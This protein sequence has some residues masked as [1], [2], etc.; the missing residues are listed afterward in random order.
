M[1]I[2]STEGGKRKKRKR[3]KSKRNYRTNQYIRITNV[4]LESLLSASFPSPGA[5]VHLTFLGCPPTL[6]WPL[7]LLWGQL[8]LWSSS[9]V[10]LPPMSTA[11]RTSEF[12]F[13]RIRS[14]LLCISQTQILL[15][16]SC[17]FNL[18]LEGRFCVL[19]FSTLPL[20]SIVV[21]SPPL[22]VGRHRGLL[23]RLSWRTWVCSSEFQVWRWCSCL[24]CRGPGSTKYSGELV[25]KASGNMVL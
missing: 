4:F 1:L 10:F 9:C 25:A 3:K 15:S 23:Q 8:R 22:P 13:V 19:F 14:V 6:C 18:Q 24:G 16:W 12:S 21:W 2:K 20:V 17:G 5:T 7:D 11:I